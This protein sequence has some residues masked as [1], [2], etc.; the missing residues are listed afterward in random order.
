MEHI[1]LFVWAY[2]VKICSKTALQQAAASM[3]DL[4]CTP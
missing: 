3:Q 2:L 1:L 4:R